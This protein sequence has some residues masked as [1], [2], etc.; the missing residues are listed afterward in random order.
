MIVC[1]AWIQ[2]LESW[3]LSFKLCIQVPNSFYVT[4]LIFL[5]STIQV[6]LLDF[7]IY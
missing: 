2:A 3:L 6:F 4:I 1:E 5:I 7:G